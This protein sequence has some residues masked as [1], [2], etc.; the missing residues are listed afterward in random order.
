MSEGT[1][2]RTRLENKIQ[3]IKGTLPDE[4]KENK[5]NGYLRYFTVDTLNGNS[6]YANKRDS[7]LSSEEDILMIMDGSKSG[8]VYFPQEKG[9]IGSTFA[10]IK[11]GEI[12]PYY[13][14]S[15][16]Q[17]NFN[18]INNATKG[19]AVPHT[20]K[21]IVNSLEIIDYPLPEQRKI[22]TVLYNVDQAIQ[23]TDDIIEQTN[24]VKK[25]LMQDLFTEGYFEHKEY[26]KIQIGPFTYSKPKRW[27]IETVND[28]KDGENG[29]R[30]GPF[31]GM[32]KK[33]IFVDSGYKV[34][35]QQNVIY[36][37]FDY[38]DYYITED[39]FNEMTRFRI[40]A[41][42]LLI[43]CSGTLGK[44]A[45]VPEEYQDGVINQAL[46]KFSVD[47]NEFSTSY[48]KYF[49]ESIIGQR[50]LVLSS[51]GSAMKNM[52]PMDFVKSSKIFQPSLEEQEKI[53]DILSSVD[54]KIDSAIEQKD[55][56]KR[57]KKG[58][59]Q[60]LLTGK[61]RTHDKDIEVMDEVMEVEGSG[62]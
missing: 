5:E 45:K 17:N 27:D 14:Y 18:R 38:G 9:V 10:A 59:M 41:G 34:Y 13:L 3:I 60:D 20:D 1:G 26:E 35:Q 62:S 58:L 57:I 24:R 50:Q 7:K 23:K 32:L 25:G 4:V 11:T 19:S 12:N 6:H 44:I 15:F 40:K 21:N 22:S 43:S 31:G 39:K 48:M 54:I 53:A 52:A 47:K 46:L 51:R 42:D 30:R 56:L 33:E 37:D 28:A 8:R 29:L 61:V 55:N 16:L 2:L 49:L 36:E